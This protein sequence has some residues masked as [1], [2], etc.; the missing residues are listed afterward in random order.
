MSQRLM[1]IFST[2]F[3]SLADRQQTPEQSRASQALDRLNA[4]TDK[5]IAKGSNPLSDAIDHMAEHR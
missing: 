4:T 2:F 1:M 3:H 5:I